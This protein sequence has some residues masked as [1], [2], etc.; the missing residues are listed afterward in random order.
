MVARKKGNRY[1]AAIKL[2][3]KSL[4]KVHLN[5]GS[6]PMNGFKDL[7]VPVVEED[8][9]YRLDF[10]NAHYFSPELD[11]E[12]FREGL[13]E[14]VERDFRE[15]YRLRDKQREALEE[16]V[17]ISA[18]RIMKMIMAGEFP[19]QINLSFY[20]DARIKNKRKDEILFPRHMGVKDPKL[21][22]VPS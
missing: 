8:G 14:S 6:Y 7:I 16:L 13:I 22:S 12:S 4:A 19:K 2:C 3:S 1:T 10:A 17:R 21:S 9:E 15:E 11:F 18:P 20:Y 5:G